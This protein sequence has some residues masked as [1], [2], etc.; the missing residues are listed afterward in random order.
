MV[1]CSLCG[2]D[3]VSKATC[4]LNTNAKNPNPSKHNISKSSNKDSLHDLIDNIS[5]SCPSESTNL[6]MLKTLIPDKPIKQPVQQPVKQPVKQ[7]DKKPKK[8]VKKPVKKVL[9]KINL[10][11]IFTSGYVFKSK[12]ISK[13][14]N[15][16]QY[17]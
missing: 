17:M 7:Q 4:P 9:N 8:S 16:V 6:N 14:L 2:A 3:G 12:G 1:K 11:T 10:K 5:K 15:H 13:N